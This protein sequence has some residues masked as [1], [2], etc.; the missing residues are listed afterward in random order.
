MRWDFITRVANKEILSTFR[1]R[2]TLTSTIVLPLIMIP[3]MLIGLPLVMGR[4]FGGEQERRQEIGV[5]GLDRAPAALVQALTTDAPGAAGVDLKPVTDA[6]KA[7]QDKAVE[8]AIVIPERVPAEAGGQPVLIEVWAKQ[9]SMKSSFVMQKIS[10]AIDA[11]GQ[12]LVAAKL[13]EAG[14]PPETM[15]PVYAEA[16]AA[17]TAAEQASGLLA[18]LIP[19]FIIQW[20]LVGGQATAVDAT[21]GEKERGT[22]E[23]L[24]VTPISRLE[25]V[26]GKLIAV[27]VFSL[28]ATVF[29]MVGLLL[30][31]ILSRTLLSSALGNDASLSSVSGGTNN[32]ATM[33]GGNLAIGLGGFLQLLLV[34]ITAAAFISALLLAVSV[35]ARSFKEAQTYIAPLTLLI[36]LPAV[37]LQFAE[38]LSSGT[39]YYAIPI[40]GSMLV[41]LDVVKGIVNWGNGGIVIVVNTACALLALVFALSSF[42]KEKVLFRN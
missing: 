29:S 13:R 1:D 26:V 16:K 4:A 10:Q 2:R 20:I 35:F 18:F 8:A 6:L 41:I 9:S 3:L 19:M 25:I 36:V 22:L 34:G 33:F 5:V 30:T 21:A 23:A 32:M 40:V 39:A 42:R 17:D 24:L 14:L 38:F 28:M 11:Y 12:G 7:V 15:R 37:M 31:G 27:I